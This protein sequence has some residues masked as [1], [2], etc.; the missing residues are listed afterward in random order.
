MRTRKDLQERSDRSAIPDRHVQC[1]AFVAED[2]DLN[3][4]EAVLSLATTSSGPEVSES[5]ATCGMSR[6]SYLLLDSLVS[7]PGA[8]RPQARSRP[9][10][11]GRPP[12][13]SQ[14]SRRGHRARHPSDIPAISRATGLER[15]AR[16]ASLPLGAASRR[17][18]V[19]GACADC[20]RDVS[21]V[22]SSVGD[23]R[24]ALRV[25]VL[26]N[27]RPGR[28]GPQRSRPEL[29]FFS[30]CRWSSMRPRAT[31]SLLELRVSCRA[32]Q[33]QDPVRRS[34]VWRQAG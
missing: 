24:D 6:T 27:P 5:L 1:K 34:V 25:D 21:G 11:H 15:R 9:A 26:A 29:S 8:S 28:R 30:V 10:P 23:R 33:V 20:G 3:V 17:R 16:R 32:P 12:G 4:I 22:A 14:R 31:A 18:A 7:A 13:R 19:L 2:A